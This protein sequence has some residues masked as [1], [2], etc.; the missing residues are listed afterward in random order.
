ML[1]FGPWSNSQTFAQK[2][3]TSKFGHKQ[4]VLQSEW[5][6][7]RGQNL[8]NETLDDKPHHSENLCTSCT[9]GAFEIQTDYH[10]HTS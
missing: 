7:F 9:T 1:I 5:S 4:T 8:S 10:G 3:N 6:I 2:C